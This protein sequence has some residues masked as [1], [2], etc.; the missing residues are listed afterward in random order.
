MSVSSKKYDKS[1]HRDCESTYTQ[2]RDSREHE[3]VC[4]MK[5]A[6]C[7]CGCVLD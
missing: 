2:C 6:Q 4:N 3:S 5:R 1:C 7:S